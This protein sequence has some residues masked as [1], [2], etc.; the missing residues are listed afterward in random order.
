M[1][2]TSN[3]TSRI[4]GVVSFLIKAVVIIGVVGIL[5]KALASLGA[6]H[7]KELPEE[8]FSTGY[9]TILKLLDSELFMGLIFLIT[10]SVFAYVGYLLWQLHEIALHKA[11]R[12]SSPQIQLVFALSLCGLFI[13]KTW[14]VLALIIVF[15]SW[16]HIM[17]RIS[18]I[19]GKGVASAQ[20]N[21]D[22]EKQ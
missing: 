16:E 12:D 13:D 17:V 5:S 11:K 2:D 7:G 9:P 18:D 10:L 6:I 3:A 1:N 22:K 20:V 14:W 15:T 8:Y 19:I 21:E 4:K